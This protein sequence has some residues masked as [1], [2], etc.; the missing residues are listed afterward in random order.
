MS[1]EEETVVELT[2]DM[3]ACRCLL[4]SVSHRLNDWP[5]GAP[6]EQQLL[7]DMQN[8]LQRCVLELS[9]NI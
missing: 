2:L 3:I 9:L 6:E 7:K 5:G 8:F 4:Q 1:D